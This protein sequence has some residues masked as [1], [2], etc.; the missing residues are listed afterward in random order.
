MK[1]QL[2]YLGVAVTVIGFLFLVIG[3]E[4]MIVKPTT[5]WLDFFFAIYV[6][7]LAALCHRY[8]RYREKDGYNYGVLLSLVIS[9]ILIALMLK[10]VVSEAHIAWIIL[11]IL[12]SAG[13][14][15]MTIGISLINAPDSP[16]AIIDGSLVIVNLGMASALMF[17][18]A[19]NQRQADFVWLC[20]AFLV[21][22]EMLICFYFE[23][24][25]KSQKM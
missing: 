12:A 16:A 6:I 8:S 2:M 20:L 1:K 25:R 18:A 15:L 4:R 10:A 5:K 11:A 14:A 19:V 21:L 23:I 13:C 3:F 22:A 9:E 17:L 24:I 7:S